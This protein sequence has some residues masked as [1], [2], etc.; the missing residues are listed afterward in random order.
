MTKWLSHPPSGN[1]LH[2]SPHFPIH[3][4]KFHILFPQSLC[5]F[6]IFPLVFLHVS[7]FRF[8]INMGQWDDTNWV[9]QSKDKSLVT[10][11]LKFAIATLTHI[12]NKCLRKLTFLFCT[13]K[14]DKHLFN[15]MCLS[16]FHLLGQQ[17]FNHRSIWSEA[18]CLFTHLEIS[19]CYWSHF[20]V[21][22]TLE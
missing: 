20:L 3:F 10:I 13:Y 11:K 18:I 16:V 7:Y 5:V 8:Y 17:A 22:H 6:P 21:L 2:L 4:F 15:K 9:V 14:V 12:S 1:S 19:I